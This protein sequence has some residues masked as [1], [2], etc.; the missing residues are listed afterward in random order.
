MS[1]DMAEVHRLIHQQGV[2]EARR[3]AQSKHD[4]A[5]VDA[6]YQVLSE[7][8]N[9]VGFTYS[10]SYNMAHFIGRMFV[11]YHVAYFH[12]GRGRFN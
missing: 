11:A 4:R 8:A 1:D 9:R 12:T 7:E 10:G 5:V 2:E 3:Q 6:A